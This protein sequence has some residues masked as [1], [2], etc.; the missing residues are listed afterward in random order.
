MISKQEA[1]A[2]ARDECARRGWGWTEPVRVSWGI[3]TYT[4]CTNCH[5][6]GGNA[7]LVIRKRDGVI[8]SAT[9]SPM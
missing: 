4:V 2:I 8:T 6:R 9:I 7:A 3:F 1:L 5:S